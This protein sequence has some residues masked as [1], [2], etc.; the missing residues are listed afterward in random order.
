VGGGESG[1]NLGK[2]WAKLVFAGRLAA[3]AAAT[4]AIFSA[5]K[6]PADLL[7]GEAI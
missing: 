2:N 7:A 5:K 3:N 6:S 4:A 1:A